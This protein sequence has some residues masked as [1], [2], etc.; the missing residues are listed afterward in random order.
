MKYGQQYMIKH[1]ISRMG[2]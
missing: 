2:Q 1:T